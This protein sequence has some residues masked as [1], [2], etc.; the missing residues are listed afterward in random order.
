MEETT[1]INTIAKEAIPG[2]QFCQEDVIEDIE[3]QK[4]RLKNLTK[5]TTLGNGQRRK[6]NI[7]FKTSQ[8]V[9]NQVHT[10]VWAVGD[11]FISLKAGA[12]IPINS[13]VQ[14]KF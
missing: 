11:R 14:V 4:L 2:V 3:N 1:T 12:S 5:A 6:V 7:V 9:L 8:G 10:T 13:I